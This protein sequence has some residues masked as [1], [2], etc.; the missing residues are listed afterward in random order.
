MKER[1]NLLYITQY[2]VI[3]GLETLIV[4][5]CKNINKNTF[6]VQVLCLNGYDDNYKDQ[7]I[8]K[9][10]PVYLI[11]K[12]KKTDI[13]FFKKII[14]FLKK[15]KIHL[16][17]AHSGCFFYAAV[18][19]KIAGVP[20]FMY[21]SHGL[22]TVDNLQTHIED[23]IATL[24]TDKII[25]VSDE[26]KEDFESRNPP[27]A[28]KIAILINGVNTATFKPISDHNIID[29]IKKRFH[30]PYGKKIIGSVGRLDKVKNYRMLIRAFAD[31]LR[32]E[33]QS[34]YLVFI[35][36]GYER[37]D[38]ERYA[39]NLEVSS[40]ISF[41]G[42][43]YHIET[44]LPIFDIFVLSS[45][46]EGTSVALLEAQSCGVPAVVTDVGGNSSIIKEGKNGLLCRS[47]DHKG[48]TAKLAILCQNEDM[49][50][51]MHSHSR[52]T[53][54]ERFSLSLMVREHEKMY[55]SLISEAHLS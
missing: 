11:K 54:V 6:N 21:T 25:A 40:S 39:E 14:S 3:G 55:K 52:K 15:H 2:L 38:L 35:G 5:L 30:I 13:L 27:A 16:V 48:L 49:L 37:E 45:F 20:K 42:L 31:L 41:L 51:K 24:M 17:H 32:N 36:D 34:A 28:K 50:N 9:G 29:K 33:S 43:Q 47:E 8:C 12:R 7:L 53:V 18:C 22:P 1:I 46:T 23:Y 26:V 44:I 19:S 4:E 10:I